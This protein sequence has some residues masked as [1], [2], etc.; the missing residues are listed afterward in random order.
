MGKFRM[1]GAAH[2]ADGA[3]AA[4]EVTGAVDPQAKNEAKRR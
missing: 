2:E 4:R 1:D 3:E